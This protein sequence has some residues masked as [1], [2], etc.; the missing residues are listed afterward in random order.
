MNLLKRHPH[1]C[2]LQRIIQTYHRFL[3]GISVLYLPLEIKTFVNYEEKLI[4]ECSNSKKG[5]VSGKCKCIGC[6]E[7]KRIYRGGVN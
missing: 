6:R 3:G 5:P 2:E 4:L 7:G 1:K